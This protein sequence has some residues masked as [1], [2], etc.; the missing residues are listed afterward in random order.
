[1]WVL[2]GRLEGAASK[3]LNQQTKAQSPLRAWRQ[4][5]GSAGIL[6]ILA[7]VGILSLSP[8]SSSRFFPFLSCLFRFLGGSSVVGTGQAWWRAETWVS[9]FINGETP[10]LRDKEACPP[11][12]LPSCVAGSSGLLSPRVSWPQEPRRVAWLRGAQAR[13]SPDAPGRRSG[14]LVICPGPS[15]QACRVL[16]SLPLSTRL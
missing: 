2:A 6:L 1:M 16:L 7:G 11:G 5:T 4:I 13:K 15:G 12:C 8:L 9:H 14:P 10:V 3:S